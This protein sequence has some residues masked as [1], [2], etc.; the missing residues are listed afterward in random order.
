MEHLTPLNALVQNN[1]HLFSKIKPFLK[2][3]LS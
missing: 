3:D 2:N 1:A